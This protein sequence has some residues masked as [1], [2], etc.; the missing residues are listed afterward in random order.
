MEAHVRKFGDEQERQSSDA[1]AHTNRQ[2]EAQAKRQQEM[3]R[4]QINKLQRN[5]GFM[6]EWHAK[7]VEDWKKNQKRKK[8]RESKQL[9]FDYKQAEKYNSIALQKL[10]DAN[11]EVQDGIANFEETLKS[12]GIN[13]RVQKDIADKAV[14]DSF[15]RTAG[16]IQPK[17]PMRAPT[18]ASQAA[19]ATAG[20]AF[21]LTSTGLK[22]RTKKTQTEESRKQREKRRRRLI[23]HQEKLMSEMELKNRESLVTEFMKRQSNQEKELDYET[24][25]TN[26][27]KDVILKNR[28][29]REEQYVKR[30]QLDT[31]TA[32]DKEKELLKS[33]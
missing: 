19:T 7:G 1:Q 24:W 8:D 21:T 4:I 11:T 31:T 16:Q 30:N 6:E 13:P 27:C 9:E 26:Q 32:V 18:R 28:H 25:R 17:S 5:A 15:S 29:L 33:M 2:K 23:G 14:T 10:D 12:Q 20:G 3:R 22:Q